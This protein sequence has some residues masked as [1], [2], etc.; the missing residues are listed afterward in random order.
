VEGR[1][2]LSPVGGGGLRRS[3]VG[4]LRE[5]RRGVDTC[6]LTPKGVRRLGVSGPSGGPGCMGA[7]WYHPHK[8]GK[9][10]AFGAKGRAILAKGINLSKYAGWKFEDLGART[11][12]GKNVREE[13][14]LFARK[15][16]SGGRRW[17]S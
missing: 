5:E 1:Y 7:S 11:V 12:V 17:R 8:P 10:S 2:S 13:C 4:L 6:S 14:T 15:A 3:R 9:M 16:H